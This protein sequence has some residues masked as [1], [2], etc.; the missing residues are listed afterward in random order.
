MSDSDQAAPTYSTALMM[1]LAA[2]VT[3]ICARH[4]GLKVFILEPDEGRKTFCL[5]NSD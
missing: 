3:T 5:H 1:L 4:P 2:E